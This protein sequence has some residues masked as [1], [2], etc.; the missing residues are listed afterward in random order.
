MKEDGGGELGRRME[1]KDE[2]GRCIKEKYQEEEWREKIRKDRKEE[3]TQERRI[4][5]IT[6]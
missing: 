4:R 3:K 5:K 6:S 1:K 2:L